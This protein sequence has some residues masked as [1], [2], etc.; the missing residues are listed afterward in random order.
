MRKRA[1]IISSIPVRLSLSKIKSPRQ[2]CRGGEIKFRGQ[3][4]MADDRKIGLEVGAIMNM[5]KRQAPFETNDN[6]RITRMQMWIINYIRKKM[7]IRDS[8]F[9]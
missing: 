9:D 1:N 7:C 8:A 4:I 2:T 6:E 3:C 5:L